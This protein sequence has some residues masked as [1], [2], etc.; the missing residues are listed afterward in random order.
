M[1]FDKR[2]ATM[3]TMKSS[4]TL[5]QCQMKLMDSASCVQSVNRCYKR[6]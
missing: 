2:G 1:M 4:R 6:Q 3:Q 5:S